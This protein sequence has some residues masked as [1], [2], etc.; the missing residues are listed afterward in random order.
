MS[1]PNTPS[2]ATWF[3]LQPATADGRKFSDAE[4][5]AHKQEFAGRLLKLMAGGT[6]LGVAARAVPS[7]VNTIRQ[8]ELPDAEA[9][10]SPV[11]TPLTIPVVRRKKQASATTPHP[12]K[13]VTDW[14]ANRLPDSPAADYRWSAVGMPLTAG[15]TT[16]GLLAGY[17]GTDTVMAKYKK[18]RQAKELADAE[19]D[20]QAAI[21]GDGAAGVAK[22]AAEAIDRTKAA[23]GNP[24]LLE[25]L[26]TPLVGAQ[27]VETAK[28]T[29]NTVLL[30]SLLGG[31]LVGYNAQKSRGREAALNAA[32]KARAQRRANSA[33]VRMIMQ[34]EEV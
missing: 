14:I 12:L 2:W 7:A 22:L 24:G 5:L 21:R 26:Y 34:P 23:D 3:G 16:A 25:S 20:Y 27:N 1:E 15:V 11:P 9:Y 6:A 19:A 18:Q 17:G 13:A 32:L 4:Q 8:P 30:G 10:T 33:P 31:G 28:G 29:L